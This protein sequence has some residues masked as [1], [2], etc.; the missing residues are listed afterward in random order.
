MA[1][2]SMGSP[3]PLQSLRGH[4]WLALVLW[5]LLC[6][7]VGAAGSLVTETGAWYQSLDRPP[8][9]PPS[10]VFAPVWIALYAVMAAAA[11][12]IWREPPGRRRRLALGLFLVQLAANGL[13]SPLF[14][15]LRSPG[16]ALLDMAVLLA[17]LVATIVAFA[18]VQ[19]AAAWLL[20]PYLAWVLYAASLNVWIW[21]KN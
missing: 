7:A 11:W 12:L 13:W 17:A 3:H 8:W 1:Q 6:Q 18:R 19:R 10:W 9:N 4:P 21:A 2:A 16:L 20:A 15:G 5:L 14:F